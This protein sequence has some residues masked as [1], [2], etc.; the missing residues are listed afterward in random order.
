MGVWSL[1]RRHQKRQLA[2]PV[3]VAMRLGLIRHSTDVGAGAG[4]KV[5]TLA[6]PSRVDSLALLKRTAYP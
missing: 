4:T 1:S 2:L 3:R 5:A 6:K